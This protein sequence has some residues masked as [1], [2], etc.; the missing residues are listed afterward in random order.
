MWKCKTINLAVSLG[1]IFE[2]SPYISLE[3]EY[4]ERNIQNY[5]NT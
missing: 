5:K 2:L 4:P 3:T 1:L